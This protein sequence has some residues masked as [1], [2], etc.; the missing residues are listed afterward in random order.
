LSLPLGRGLHGFLA[1]LACSFNVAMAQE[2]AEGGPAI[3]TFAELEA[4]GAIIGDIRIDNQNIF[5][6]ED[7]RE[8][9][10]FYA[11][12]NWA[13]IRTRPD[14]IR[15]QILFKTGERVSVQAIQETERLLRGNNYLYEVAI[16][17]GD[18]HDGVVDIDVTT[19]DTWTLVPSVN[20]S[21][22][23]GTNRGGVGFRD[24]NI[25]GTGVKFSI[26]RRA[27][28]ESEGTSASSTELEL[29]NPNA[30]GGH[31]GIGY[32]MSKFSGGRVNTF[33]VAR[34]FYALDARW[35]AGV[36][37]SRDDRVVSTVMNGT[38]VEQFR[39]RQDKAE[40]S[41]GLSRGLVDR[42]A[43]RYSLGLSYE[44]DTYG[45]APDAAPDVQ[46]PADRKL[47]A[48]FIRYEAIED[49]FRKVT[50]RDLIGRT[51]FLAMGFH[52]I[53]Q[54]GRALPQLGSTSYASLYSVGVSNGYE[55]GAAGTLL[56]SAYYAGEYAGEHSDRRQWNGTLKYYLAQESG[57]VF[58][59]LLA[60]DR[61]QF[62]D[63]SQSLTLGGDNGLRGYPSHFQS[64]DRRVLFTAEQR[65][66]T[67]WFPY[68]LFR[69]GGALFL[70]A[71]RA[72]SGPYDDPARSRWLGDVGFGVRILSARS[73]TGTT[74]H[75]DFAFPLRRDEGVRSYQF[76]FMSKTGF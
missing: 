12:A 50:N 51:E 56:G 10:S 19:R 5:D 46:V 58:Y 15:R 49:D 30:F 9:K 20:L 11:F 53:A 37:A 52:S 38:A 7:A 68:R 8:N 24:S 41:G 55:M 39:R 35:A 75:L 76:S 21:R 67:D 63:A 54:F 31:T 59:T 69:V 16:R 14:V 22:S 26:G 47:I 62:S 61:V 34:P 57:S 33:S 2:P 66:Y 13:H 25:A 17:P 70:D 45:P 74:L 60:A 23:G 36:S 3:P 29:T 64:G 6:L 40:V 4:A 27:S 1:A 72:W 65:F 32:T 44:S 18:V 73:S 43:H 28:S 48:P 71:G 42:W